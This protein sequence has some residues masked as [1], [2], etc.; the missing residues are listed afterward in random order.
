MDRPR[1]RTQ[2]YKL[3]QVIEL[4][5]SELVLIPQGFLSWRDMNKL[6]GGGT[7]NQF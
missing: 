7:D 6:F 3:P 4:L 5:Q 2:T 1:Y